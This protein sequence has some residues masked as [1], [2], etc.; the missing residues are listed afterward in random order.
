M[1]PARAPDSVNLSERPMDVNGKSLK[2]QDF[3]AM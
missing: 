2:K 3:I 1:R